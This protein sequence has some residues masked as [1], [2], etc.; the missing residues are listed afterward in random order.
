MEKS[1]SIFKFFWY[2]IRKEWYIWIPLIMC[3]YPIISCNCDILRIPSDFDERTVCKINNI[4]L[5]IVYSYVAGMIVYII[6]TFIPVSRKARVIIPVVVESIRK[7]KSESEYIEGKCYGGSWLKGQKETV[8]NDTFTALCGQCPDRLSDY[9]TITINDE[10]KVILSHY[11]KCIDLCFKTFLDYET[12]FTSNECQL[13]TDI[14]M[15]FSSWQI[16]EEF[17]NISTK[18]SLNA[19][20]DDL[21]N[22]YQKIMALDKSLT[23]YKYDFQM[24]L[25]TKNNKL[26]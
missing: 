7:L 20:I 23:V 2:R 17:Q 25:N 26:V 18:E 13:I 1:T 6:T 3:I 11:K 22:V 9:D 14:K 5:S 10:H 8:F 21:I 15:L 19:F 24:N 12:Y 16:E 4:I